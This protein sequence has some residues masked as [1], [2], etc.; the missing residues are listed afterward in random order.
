MAAT[1]R[2][3]RFYKATRK[4]RVED[5]PIPEP[6]PGEVLVKVEYCGIC[7]SDLSLIDG[8]FGGLGTPDVITQGHEASGTIAKL[9]PGVVGWAEGDRVIPR[10]RSAVRRL[11]L[12]R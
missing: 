11:R 7:H 2:A 3:Q 9:G 5:V 12:L 8:V 4:Y 6:G 10:R 1:M